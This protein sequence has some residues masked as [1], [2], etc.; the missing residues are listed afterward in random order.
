MFST[1]MAKPKF[2]IG[3]RFANFCPIF[4]FLTSK[5][6]EDQGLSDKISQILVNWSYIPVLNYTE[7]NENFQNLR[8]MK[9][10]HLTL[11]PI[12]FYGS[13]LILSHLWSTS[14]DLYDFEKNPFCQICPLRA[15]FR[16][17][18]VVLFFFEPVPSHQFW[19]DLQKLTF[20]H[21]SWPIGFLQNVRMVARFIR[22]RGV[23]PDK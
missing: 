19:S 9:K 1:K 18:Q 4:T 2:W 13:T 15:F 14:A 7:K 16:S 23:A 8:K 3:R 17:S 5:F 20:M 22:L 10:N 21:T 6:L 11:F 12:E